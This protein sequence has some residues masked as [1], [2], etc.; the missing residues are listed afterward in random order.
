MNINFLPVLCGVTE[1]ETGRVL[2]NK[3]LILR[4]I[5]CEDE[6][7]FELYSKFDPQWRV[8]TRPIMKNLLISF[9]ATARRF[10]VQYCP[11][12]LP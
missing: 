2:L 5:K 11:E 8:V 3:T 4:A 12:M 6:T 9:G 1:Y 10:I 7:R